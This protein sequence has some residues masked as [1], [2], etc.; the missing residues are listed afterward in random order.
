MNFIKY[1]LLVINIISF[2]IV[3]LI[4]GT[5]GIYEFFND[6]N[7]TDKML[8]RIHCPLNTRQITV[9]AVICQLICFI[10]YCLRTL[11]LKV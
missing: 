6:D 2:A 5:V 7:E 1:A 9:L 11:V 8:K 4:A 3:V 10:T